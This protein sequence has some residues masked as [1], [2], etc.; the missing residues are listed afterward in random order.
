MER[1][2][3]GVCSRKFGSGGSDISRKSKQQEQFGEVNEKKC[4]KNVMEEQK[5]KC[6]QMQSC[7]QNDL[8]SL[9]QSIKP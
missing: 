4:N 3:Y 6:I 7:H 1:G 9:Y 8:L 2:G 5:N